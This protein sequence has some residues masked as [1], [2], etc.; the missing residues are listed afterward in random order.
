MPQLL[1]KLASR[2][3]REKCFACI[4]N[5]I[6]CSTIS[7]YIILLSFDVDDPEM[8]GDEVKERLSRYGDKVKAYWG[9]SG[10]KVAAINRDISFIED[11][12]IVLNHSD[13][14]WI[15][16]PGFD[17]AVISA[18]DKYFPDGDGMVHFPDQVALSRLCTYQIVGKK[19]FDRTSYIYCPEYF[20][21][22]CDNEEFLKS[23][24]L[25]KY[26]YIPEFY[27]EHR[28]AIWGYGAA[29][30]LLRH[31]ERFYQIDGTTFNKRLADNFGIK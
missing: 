28:H 9:I 2:S 24:K 20:S 15:T 17:S 14:F 4:E 23:Q 30:A 21:L 13:D 8:Q 16:K 19:Y 25:G 29:D 22:F 6:S 5:I 27:L 1:Y 26:A 10:S 3:R 11:F 12:D 31:T 18:M 7:D